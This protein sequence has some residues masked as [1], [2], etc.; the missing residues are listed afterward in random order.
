VLP[1]ETP[2]SAA[3]S[4]DALSAAVSQLEVGDRVTLAWTDTS[5]QAT[6]ATI[7]LGAGPVG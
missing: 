1:T 4:A 5:G 3:T 7:T 6:T 2:A